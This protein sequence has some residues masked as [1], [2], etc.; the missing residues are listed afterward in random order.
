MTPSSLAPHVP[1]QRSVVMDAMTRTH[2]RGFA[3]AVDVVCT[4]A[5]DAMTS[6]TRMGR[7]T[8][9]VWCAAIA[10]IG[11]G[12]SGGNNQPPP[13]PSGT[14]VSIAVTSSSPM[15]F[16]GVTETFS[17]VATYTSGAT[18]A[19]T[20]GTWTTN[21]P[22]VAPV[23]AVGKVT[24]AGNGEATIS[25]DYQGVHG[26]THVRVLPNY[27][28]NWAGSYTVVS[29]TQTEQIDFCGSF[30]VGQTF[31][32]QLLLT[33]NGDVIT[34]QTAIGL[35]GSTTVSATINTDGSVTLTPQTFVG[36]VQIDYVWSLTCSQPNAIGGTVMQTWIDAATPGQMVIQG[37]LQRP[38]R[39]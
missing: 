19:V 31:P 32:Y 16:L 39:Q 37:T 15:M 36:T 28:G 33:Q 29:C 22:A 35:L 9:F 27:G 18:Q 3:E 23:D 20:G 5:H 17:A 26:S 8:W 34:G 4:N 25:V 6:F 10:A 11:C 12:S 2:R 24:A 7:V 38:T 14:I 13:A 30:N 21:A 1:H